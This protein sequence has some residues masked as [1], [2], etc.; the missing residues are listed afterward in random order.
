MNGAASA[1]GST[2]N[3]STYRVCLDRRLRS[4]LRRGTC[5]FVQPASCRRQ[6]IGA[7]RCGCGGLGRR[8]W[9]DPPDRRITQPKVPAAWADRRSGVRGAPELAVLEVRDLPTRFCRF[10]HGSQAASNARWPPGLLVHC[11]AAMYSALGRD[12]GGELPQVIGLG[13]WSRH[14]A[15]SNRPALDAVPQP[16]PLLASGRSQPTGPPAVLES[17]QAVRSGC[18]RHAPGRS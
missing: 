10:G 5:P 8:K 6:G 16:C 13:R 17:V 7:L 2:I 1:T 9:P 3:R 11:H 14:G 15:A 4:R 12:S 18:Q